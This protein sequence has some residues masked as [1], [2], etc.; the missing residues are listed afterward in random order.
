MVFTPYM[1]LGQYHLLGSYVEA[2]VDEQNR[3]DPNFNTVD[4]PNPENPEALKLAI[5]VAQKTKSDLVL[6]SDPDCDRIGVAVR[7]EGKFKTLSGNQVASM[8]AEYRLT[9]AK[10]KNIISDEGSQ[11]V[12]LLKLCLTL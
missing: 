9:V 4:S 1:G 2:I 6:G 10:R 11:N 8:L 3:Q 7:S 12:A 5:S